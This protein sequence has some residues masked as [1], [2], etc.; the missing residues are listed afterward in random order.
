MQDSTVAYINVAW[1]QNVVK[2]MAACGMSY[3]STKCTELVY[4]K[5]TKYFMCSSQMLHQIH[6][7]QLIIRL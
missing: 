3:K 2:V 7:I 4:C 6:F 5:T 1:T